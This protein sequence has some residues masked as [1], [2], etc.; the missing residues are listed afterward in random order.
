MYRLINLFKLYQARQNLFKET[1]CHLVT[2]IRKS[3]SL[4]GMESKAEK[5]TCREHSNSTKNNSKAS[6]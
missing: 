5:V 1:H 4:G 3:Y 2:S 6:M